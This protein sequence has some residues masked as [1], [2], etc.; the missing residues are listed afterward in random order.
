[1]TLVVGSN[2]TGMPSRRLAAVDGR[3]DDAITLPGADG[4]TATVQPVRLRAPFAAFPD[5]VQY[6]IAYD[7]RT[8]TA[9]LVVQAGN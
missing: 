9:R 3:G 4:S 6:Q 1:M 5:V 7:G 2:P 8:M